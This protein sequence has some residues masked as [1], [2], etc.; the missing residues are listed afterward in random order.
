L[1]ILPNTLKRHTIRFH[2]G[3]SAKL[4][5]RKNH[6]GGLLRALFRGQPSHIENGIAEGMRLVALLIHLNDALSL[7]RCEPPEPSIYCDGFISLLR[8]LRP[9]VQELL[10][11]AAGAIGHTEPKLFA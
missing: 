1:A 6:F 5:D 11:S 10:H 9:V 3:A 7:A 8:A 4:F 2:K